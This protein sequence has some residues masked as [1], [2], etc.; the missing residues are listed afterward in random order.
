MWGADVIVIKINIDY[1]CKVKSINAIEIKNAIE[2][3]IILST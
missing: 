2:N 3:S 1:L